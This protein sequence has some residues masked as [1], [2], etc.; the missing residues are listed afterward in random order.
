MV[1]NPVVDILNR[2]LFPQSTKIQRSARD[3][4]FLERFRTAIAQHYS[5]PGF[6]TSAAADS[7]EMSRMHL[8]RKL[9]EMTG[10]STHEFIKTM[11]LEAARDLLPKPLPVAFIARSVGFKSSSHFAGVFREKFGAPPSQYRTRNSL[12]NN[13]HSRTKRSPR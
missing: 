6:T 9:R 11:R 7:V 10:L 3:Q 8:N 13:S 4:Q 2:F 12:E 5:D 1:R